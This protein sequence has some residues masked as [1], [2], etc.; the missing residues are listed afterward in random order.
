MNGGGAACVIEI[1]SIDASGSMCRS[2]G[3]TAIS[4]APV[5]LSG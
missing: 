1:G 5:R 4:A 2:G 3:S